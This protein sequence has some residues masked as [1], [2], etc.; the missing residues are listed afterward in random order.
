MFQ[1][2]TMVKDH[3]TKY[4]IGNI[5]SVMDGN[6]DPFI[7]EYFKVEQGS[8]RLKPVRLLIVDDL[9]FMRTAIRQIVESAGFIVAGEAENGKEAVEKYAEFSPDIVLLDITMPVMDGLAALKKIIAADSEARVVMCSALGRLNTS[10]DQSS[11]ARDF[12]VKPF[13]PSRLISAL[14]KAAGG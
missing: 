12:I 5:Q 11:W 4:E 7:E 3:R 13:K 2:Y 8:G 1:P 10:S 14:K 6:I 9:V